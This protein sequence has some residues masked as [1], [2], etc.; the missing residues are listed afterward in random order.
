MADVVGEAVQINS[1]PASPILSAWRGSAWRATNELHCS[2]DAISAECNQ[3]VHDQSHTSRSML[4][5]GKAG[6]IYGQSFEALEVALLYRSPS[7]T[8]EEQKDGQEHHLNSP[9]RDMTE[10]QRREEMMDMTSGDIRQRHDGHT[11]YD[12]TLHTGRDENQN[13]HYER[14]RLDYSRTGSAAAS[15]QRSDRPPI[16]GPSVQDLLNR[17]HER[18]GACHDE[19]YDYDH[20]FA[21]IEQVADDSG[22][23]TTRLD[24]LADVCEQQEEPVHLPY[25]AHQDSAEG[26]LGQR[27][28]W[29]INMSL[30]EDVTDPINRFSAEP[31]SQQ[32]EQQKQQQQQ[33]HPQSRQLYGRRDQQ[34]QTHL[35]S[36][37]YPG[38]LLPS[39]QSYE[40]AASSAKEASSSSAPAPRP[41]LPSLQQALRGAVGEVERARYSWQFDDHPEGEAGIDNDRRQL[42]ASPSLGS[43]VIED[44][45]GFWE[46][47]ALGRR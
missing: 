35:P 17:Y 6:L 4:A 9:F 25:L 26:Q 16:S 5:Q 46:P 21:S 1:R 24:D 44:G 20:S 29:S 23:G 41:Y 3:V 30:K 31:Q 28:D 2:H 22:H 45:G 7:G 11:E 14:H 42:G 34:L 47:Q 10:S 32:V 33:L 43:R 38:P 36:Q 18:Y 12:L 15:N 13:P 40:C 27:R 39:A 37:S 19:T 8:Q